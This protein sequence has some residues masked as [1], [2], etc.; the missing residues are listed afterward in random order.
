MSVGP[1]PLPRYR[2]PVLLLVAALMA[3][4]NPQA[5]TVNGTST[6][7]SPTATPVPTSA[8][9]P[10][11]TTVVP[12]PTPGPAALA[13]VGP[14]ETVF[15]WSA[16]RCATDDI[17]DLPA[18]AFKDAS[19]TVQLISSHI[20]TRRMIGS[21]L[22]NV[23]RDCTIR[24]RSDHNADPA[25]FDDN[26]WLAAPYTED[27]STIYALVHM[28]YHGWE[29]SSDCQPPNHFPCWYNSITLAAS[30]DAGAS[31][32][33]AADPPNQLVASLPDRYQAGAGPYGVM[34]PSNI[35][36]MDDYDYAFVRIDEASSDQQRICLMRTDD[37][38]SPG[39]WRFW[40]GEAFSVEMG[41]P[42]TLPDTAL[43]GVPCAAISTD[44]LGV[45]DSSVTFNTYLNRYVMVGTT[46]LHLGGRDV[47]GVL[48]STSNDLIHWDQ[49]QLLFEAKLPWT[50]QPGDG[51]YMLYPSLL[52]P[53]STSRNF[54]TSGKTAYVYFTRFNRPQA[55]PLDRD[56]VRVPVEFFDSAEA[57]QAAS[58][59]F[60]I[61][62]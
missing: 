24:M 50:W 56:L 3:G 32:A 60:V 20:Q 42:Y 2:L 25:Q 49:R 62:P 37:L 27:G 52:D 5:R 14:V 1:V 10:T 23:T 29:H 17:P 45:M 40:D 9:T 7:N 33:D 6:A 26:E 57:A 4:C 30:S 11:P 16:G 15:D 47:W 12:S 61:Q 59:P 38:T 43:G 46:A 34:E 19:G 13:V 21:S 53:S 39:S 36:K 8:P 44:A 55:Q 58:V 48:Y 41:D 28:E 22:N 51:A 31:Y 35:V 54:E 18:R